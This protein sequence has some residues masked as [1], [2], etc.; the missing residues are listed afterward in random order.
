[1]KKIILFFIL[2]SSTHAKFASWVM[3]IPCTGIELKVLSCEDKRFSNLSFIKK[4]FIS[5]KKKKEIIIEGALVKGDILKTAPVSCREK[6]KLD[7]D[8]YKEGNYK[9]KKFLVLDKS[10]AKINGEALII[11]ATKSFC[12]TPGAMEIRDCFYN[13][14][15]YKK[16]IIISH[17]IKKL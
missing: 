9:G 3:N 16:N 6:Q 14:F 17:A 8:R 11:R 13:S 5:K 15:Q 12:D 4:A 7:L 10:C 1:M 2:M